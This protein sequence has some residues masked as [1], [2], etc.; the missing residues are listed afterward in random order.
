MTFQPRNISLQLLPA[1][2]ASQVTFEGFDGLEFMLYKM[3]GL[4]CIAEASTGLPIV[5]GQD[6]KY[7]ATDKAKYVLA[8]HGVDKTRAV[9]AATLER[10]ADKA[11]AA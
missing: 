10:I 3:D 5:R 4:W 6:S 2:D 8:G 7:A 9:V 1:R 11:V